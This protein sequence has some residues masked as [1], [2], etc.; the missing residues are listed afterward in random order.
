MAEEKEEKKELKIDEKSL[1][2]FQ[3]DRNILILGEINEKM[4][5][6][7]LLRLLYLD[8][9][10]PD[11]EITIYIHSPGGSVSAGLIIVDAMQNVRAP[12]RTVDIGMAASMASVILASGSKGR[13]QIFE[14]AKVLIH[15]P[16]IVMGGETATNTTQARKLYEDMAHEQEILESIYALHSCGKYTREDYMKLTDKGDYTMEA[17]EAMKMALVDSIIK[18]RDIK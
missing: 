1:E 4:A 5:I 15:Q 18:P 14:H 2:L 16:M 13:R 17:D 9:E 11:K 12:I 6:N 7:I 8:Y 3:K 10:N